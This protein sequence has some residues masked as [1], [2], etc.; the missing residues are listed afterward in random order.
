MPEGG[1]WPL[2]LYELALLISAELDSAASICIITPESSP[3]GLFGKASAETVAKVLDDGGVETLLETAPV[4]FRDGTLETSDGR[5]IDA[6]LVIALPLLEGRRIQGLPSDERGFI[7]VD[8]FGRIEEQSR[9]YAA[10]DVTSF[11]VKFGGLATEQ[12]DVVAQAIAAAA[13]GAPAP[14]PFEPVYR[15]TLVTPN[16][17]IGLGRGA[18]DSAPYGWDPA[19]KVQGRYLTRFLKTADPAALGSRS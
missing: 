1:S 2:P 7:P 9:E 5:H 8:H 3:L 11:P 19:E 12:A 13:W 4:E 16:G 15:G 14:E 18:E 10:G 17:Q 6:D